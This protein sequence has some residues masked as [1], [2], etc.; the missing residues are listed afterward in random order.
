MSLRGLRCQAFAEAECGR[1]AA[2][3]EDLRPVA[4][5]DWGCWGSLSDCALFVKIKSSFILGWMEGL[6][7][8]SRRSA[9]GW[10]AARY[11]LLGFEKPRSQGETWGTRISGESDLGHPPIWIRIPARSAGE[12]FPHASFA[13]CAAS[14]AAATSCAFDRGISQKTCPRHGRHILKIL[15]RK[16]SSPLAP[17]LVPIPCPKPMPST[18]QHPRL[19]RGQSRHKSLIL[20]LPGVGAHIQPKPRPIP[21]PPNHTPKASTPVKRA[22]YD[23]S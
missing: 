9:K 14:R 2:R 3:Q 19:Q 22:L 20:R 18:T 4:R 12:L 8:G 6:G 1:R 7:F 11:A 17:N 23:C 21:T 16:R 15:T 5:P 10:N 13:A